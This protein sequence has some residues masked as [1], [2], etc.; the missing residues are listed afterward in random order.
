[1]Q[2][3]GGV[4]YKGT[5]VRTCAA[6]RKESRFQGE[7]PTDGD[8]NPG[9]SSLGLSFLSFK[10]GTKPF[11]RRLDSEKVQ[12]HGAGLEPQGRRAQ[13]DDGSGALCAVDSRNGQLETVP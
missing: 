2:H 8:S 13:G 6:G 3:A 10:M 9:S 12:R 4:G 5:V 1:M 7:S 11:P